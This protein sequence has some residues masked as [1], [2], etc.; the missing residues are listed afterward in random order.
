M[1]DISNQ[2][3]QLLEQQGVAV[4]L[5]RTDNVTDVDLQPRVDLAERN[6]A[7]AFVSIHANSINM[8]RP[9]VNGLQTY[10]YESANFAQVVATSK[11]RGGSP[12]RC[13]AHISL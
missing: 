10:Y 9:D 13:R 6:N 12:R 8:S 2:V 5:S 7:S 3:A 4:I 1:W 11:P